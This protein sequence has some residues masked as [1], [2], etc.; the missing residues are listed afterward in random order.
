MTQPEE[1]N[2]INK[3]KLVNALSELAKLIVDIEQRMDWLE[4]R[5]DGH[6]DFHKNQSR[7]FL[8]K[9][10]PKLKA[11]DIKIKFDI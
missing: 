11:T 5:L 10:M 9:R 7:L 8:S 2:S 4:E 1:D 6:E 3:E